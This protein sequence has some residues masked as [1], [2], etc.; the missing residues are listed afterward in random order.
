[1]DAT[2]GRSPLGAM[3]ARSRRALSAAA[4]LAVALVGCWYAAFHSVTLARADA[5]AY[6]AFYGLSL[7]HGQL[8]QIARFV[9]DL[10]M[11]SP[12]V[13]LAAVPVIIAL[14]RRRWVLAV[15][16]ALMIPGAV[17]TSELLKPLLEAA[18]PAA[19]VSNTPISTAGSWPS[20]HSTAA[21]ILSM[22]FLLASPARWRA[23][24]AAAGTLFSL[25]VIY[26]VLSLGWH[27]PSDALG[28]ILVA[29][30]WTLV[31]VAAVLHVDAHLGRDLSLLSVTR[32]RA[33]AVGSLSPVLAAALMLCAAGVPALLVLA[34]RGGSAVGYASGHTAFIVSL[35]VIAA[36]AALA[37]SALTVTL[38]GG[39]L[40]SGRTVRTAQR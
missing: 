37:T 28:G 25:A 36:L 32:H 11:P 30:I 27:Y 3:P 1:M 13:Y 8:A 4:L 2:L 39:P 20:G 18:R 9:A 5:H 7:H 26:S 17:L 14:A 33:P 31:T 23:W 19:G 22:A 15:G 35:V 16:L 10:C 34:A 6:F 40:R 12:Y 21:M 38:G 29:S 24:V